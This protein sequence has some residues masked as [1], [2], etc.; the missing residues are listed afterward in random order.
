MGRVCR[1]SRV[2]DFRILL[3]AGSSSRRER[4]GG[5]WRTIFSRLILMWGR[6]SSQ[7][8]SRRREEMGTLFFSFYA[9]GECRTGLSDWRDDGRR[10]LSQ[11]ARGT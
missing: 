4:S 3:L 6:I 11:T 2:G 8:Q 1:V 7:Q 9:A 10:A 5:L